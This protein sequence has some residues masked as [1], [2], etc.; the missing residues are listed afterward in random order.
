MIRATAISVIDQGILSA[1]NFLFALVLIRFSTQEEYGLYTQLVGL[2]S[3]FSVLHAG[4]FVSAFLSM[5]PRLSGDARARYRAG[6]ARAE[7]PVTLV[8]MLFV[9]ASTWWVARLLG[10]SIAMFTSMAAAAA[11]LSLWWREFVRAGHF[12]S[13][14][15]LQALRLDAAFAVLVIVALIAVLRAR[16]VTAANVMWC[17]AAAGVAV[18]LVPIVRK[19]RES[20]VGSR[21]VRASVV[22]SWQAARWEVLTSLVTWSHAQTFVYFAAAQGGLRA[23]AQISAARLLTMPLALIWASYA[24]IL[25][26]SASQLMQGP[27]GRNA[28]LRIARRSAIF[29]ASMACGY[30]L[31]LMLAMPLLDRILFDGKVDNLTSLTMLWL[32]YF[33]LTGM[34]TVAA[35]VLRSALEFKAVF[36]IYAVC[37]GVA[38][39]ASFVG[40]A[41]T[42][43]AA[44]IVVLIGVE[45]VLAALLWR[46]LRKRLRAYS[47][48]PLI[49]PIAREA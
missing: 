2:Q 44:F 32:I 36:G 48:G 46:L 47:S 27:D 16:Q 9:A 28:V 4:L 8:S 5:S 1:I 31:L 33:S 21:A 11:L 43:S 26:P 14:Q 39:G 6:M 3:L 18:T 12:A 15:P 34:T 10:G 30:G 24:N 22:S 42:T 38:L 37:A 13:L 29:V 45:L 7:I 35:S 25:R 20:R 17:I 41:F 40:L 23:A 49:L 19:A